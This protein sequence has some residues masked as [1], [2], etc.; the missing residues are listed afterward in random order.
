[1]KKEGKAF[2]K[3][4]GGFA[5]QTKTQKWFMMRVRKTWC[6]YRFRPNE[7]LPHAYGIGSTWVDAVYN[8][9]WRPAPVLAR[10]KR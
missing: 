4:D 5:I 7:A 10:G 9:N 1:M 2:K 8:A 6:A 3:I